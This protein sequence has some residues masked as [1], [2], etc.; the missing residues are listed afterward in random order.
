M[1]TAVDGALR[2]ASP[3]TDRGYEL[4]DQESYEQ[5]GNCWILLARGDVRIRILNDR[6]Q[7][8][9]E[10]GSEAAPDE[11]FDARVVLD[12]VGVS[13]RERGTTEVALESVCNALVATAPR[14][15]LLF[16]RTTFPTARRLL[17][18]REIQLARSEF[19]VDL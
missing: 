16:L 13:R 3:L 11:W 19:G 14:W 4:I 10:V 7:W 15:E 2:A 9:V 5:F 8:F 6:G 18:E 12:E 17:R 1:S